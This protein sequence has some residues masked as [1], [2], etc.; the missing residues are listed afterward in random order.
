MPIGRRGLRSIEGGMPCDR[1]SRKGTIRRAD[2]ADM[3][4]TTRL[5][6]LWEGLSELLTFICSH[7]RQYSRF[8]DRHREMTGAPGA[9]VIN[10]ISGLHARCAQ[11]DAVPGFLPVPV[12]VHRRVAVA[13]HDIA[14][15]T[16]HGLHRE[17][18][19]LPV[20]RAAHAAC[21][22]AGEPRIDLLDPAPAPVRLVVAERDQPGH[23]G[24]GHGKGEM[25][26]ADDA[27]DVQRLD[28]E[29]IGLGCQ[30]MRNLM[31]Q[32]FSAV[33]NLAMDGAD[34]PR[35]SVAA[36]RTLFAPR[37]NPLRSPEPL[38]RVAQM[39]WSDPFVKARTIER[40]DQRRDAKINAERDASCLHRRRAGA[41][42]LRRDQPSVA[43]TPDA[44]RQQAAKGL[45]LS[46][47]FAPAACW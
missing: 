29:H 33:T 15:V 4:S 22:A 13:V 25:P 20:Q 17:V 32:V 24:I 26:V 31:R 46:L 35:L 41:F 38:L 9:F 8:N 34:A 14:A 3:I 30:P 39:L 44:G 47:L 36:C 28:L 16:A 10:V 19:H 37:E 43:I 1:R 42:E 2:V 27:P 5:R 40:G 12:V 11:K 7:D 21:L 18:F 45:I 6:Y 23:S